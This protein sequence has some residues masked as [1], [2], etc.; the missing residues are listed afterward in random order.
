MEV[1]KMSKNG[2]QES[3]SVVAQMFCRK[4]PSRLKHMHK[5]KRKQTEHA[6]I[7]LPHESKVPQRVGLEIHYPIV[8]TAI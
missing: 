1:E 4:N 6:K 7:K 3:N 8:S 5:K 2:S